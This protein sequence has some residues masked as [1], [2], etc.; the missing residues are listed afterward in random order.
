MHERKTSKYI[1]EF[2]KMRRRCDLLDSMIPEEIKDRNKQMREGTKIDFDEMAKEQEMLDENKR[3]DKVIERVQ[4]G[5]IGSDIIPPG[6]PDDNDEIPKKMSPEEAKKSGKKKLMR[7]FFKIRMT[8]SLAQKRSMLVKSIADSR[9]DAE[10]M[11]K[12]NLSCFTPEQVQ[13]ISSI[14]DQNIDWVRLYV[15][16]QVEGKIEENS[17]DLTSKFNELQDFTLTNMQSV[18]DQCSKMVAQVNNV[19]KECQI[20]QADMKV[21][22]QQ[23]KEDQKTLVKF[24]QRL[25]SDIEITNRTMLGK[26]DDINTVFRKF[27]AQCD[28]N[29]MIISKL[30]ES[31]MID[32]LILSQDLNDK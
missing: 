31:S 21:V 19:F 5:N 20:V 9:P 18:N 6:L 16:T 26:M 2:N 14:V 27:S 29:Q 3:L 7:A 30:L 15:K 10:V 13:Q 24:K 25:W 17:S 12:R 11:K 4:V 1:K 32:S 8:L 22:E 23:F 28:R